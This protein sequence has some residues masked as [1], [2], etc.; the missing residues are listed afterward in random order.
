MLEQMPPTSTNIP[1]LK[2]SASHSS[3]PITTLFVEFHDQTKKYHLA[4]PF[5]KAWSISQN[6]KA[7]AKMRPDRWLRTW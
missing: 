3:S 7:W 1:T 4:T 6:Q 5:A 2:L